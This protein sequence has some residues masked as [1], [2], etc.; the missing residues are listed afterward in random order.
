M[1]SCAVA[2]RNACNQG[3]ITRLF[4]NDFSEAAIK[5]HMASPIAVP[6]FLSILTLYYK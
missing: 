1:V 3:F 6:C 5:K 2:M 4:F